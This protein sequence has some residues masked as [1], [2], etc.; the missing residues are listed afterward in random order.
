MENCNWEEI[1]G[2][3][4]IGKFKKFKIWLDKQVA[5]GLVEEVAVHSLSPDLVYGLKEERFLCK[6]SG[7]IWRLVFPEFPFKGYWGPN[8]GS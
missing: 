1:H 2:F 3:L 7:K 5:M 6:S 8:F 4:S